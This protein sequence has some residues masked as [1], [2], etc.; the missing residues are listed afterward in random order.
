M[1]H[2][3]VSLSK[4]MSAAR[5]I[6]LRVRLRGRIE[7]GFDTQ[8]KSGCH[9]A[10]AKG[11][12]VRLQ[13]ATLSRSVTLEATSNAVLEIGQ[14]FIGP[15]S[16][17]S[18]RDHIA[19]G[20]G[21]GIAEYVTIRDHDHLL[22]AETPLSAWQFNVAP[23]IIKDDVWIASKATVTPGVIIEEHAVCAAGAVITHDVQ[24][25]QRVGGVPARPLG[26][27]GKNAP[28]WAPHD[29]SRSSVSSS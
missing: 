22:D 28:L 4:I 21:G 25:W 1:L 26:S 6:A 23:I 3:D 11:G 9:I 15:G 12:I 18:A 5:V 13:G 19:I 27:S 16:I 8:V 29:E 2:H 10:V 24:A 20:D 7:V 14:T 17:L